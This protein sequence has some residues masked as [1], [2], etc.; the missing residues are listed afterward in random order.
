MEEE[1]YSEISAFRESTRTHED[2]RRT[3]PRFAAASAELVRCGVRPAK[4]APSCTP[5]DS[6]SQSAHQKVIGA[7]MMIQ[8]RKSKRE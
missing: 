6:L 5:P 4:F 3:L 2:A 8:L 7:D 1:V